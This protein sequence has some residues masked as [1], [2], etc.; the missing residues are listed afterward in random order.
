MTACPNGCNDIVFDYGGYQTAAYCAPFWK[1]GQFH[2]HDSN[3]H[4]SS[5]Q[6]KACGQRWIR[7]YVQ[8]CPDPDCDWPNDGAG[9]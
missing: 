7:N 6:C 4:T 8:P 5:M 2:R 9:K 1:A 3:R